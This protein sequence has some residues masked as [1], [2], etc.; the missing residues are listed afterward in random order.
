MGLAKHAI[1]RALEAS[2]Q[3]RQLVRSMPTQLPTDMLEVIKCAAGDEA[4]LVRLAEE[5]LISEQSVREAARVYLQHIVTHANGSDRLALA[6]PHGASQDD[7]RE[8]KRWMLKWLHPDR[9]PSSWETKLFYRVKDASTRLESGTSVEPPAQA[10]N[11]FRRKRPQIAKRRGAGVVGKRPVSSL[12]PRKLRKR[13]VLRLVAWPVLAAATV[14]ATAAAAWFT[15]GPL[16][17]N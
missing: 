13:D 7:I 16:G 3:P 15:F 17:G 8:H 1:D 10:D 14:A 11:L 2:R 9:N 5:R 6:L 4:T 12:Q